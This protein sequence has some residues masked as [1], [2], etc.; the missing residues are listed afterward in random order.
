MELKFSSRRGR[1]ELWV[2]RCL[3]FQLALANSARLTTYVVDEHYLN[4]LLRLE[5]HKEK[6]L[7]NIFYLL[8]VIYAIIVWMT[9]GIDFIFVVVFLSSIAIDT[10]VKTLTIA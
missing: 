6:A 1:T 9:D 4:W 8:W 5:Y 10:C 7:L 3:E 2:E